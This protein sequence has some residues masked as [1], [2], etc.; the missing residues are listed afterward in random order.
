MPPSVVA[1]ISAV[2]RLKGT[3][4]GPQISSVLGEWLQGIYGVPLGPVDESGLSVE[5]RSTDADAFA[6]QLVVSALRDQARRTVTVV[7]GVD[8]FAIVEEAPFAAPPR[9]RSSV[10]LSQPTQ[11]LLHRLLPLARPVLSLSHNAVNNVQV[12]DP[13]ELLA[14]LG[15]DLSPG[16][17]IA[18]TKSAQDAPTRSQ[19]DLLR[20]LAGLAL[21]G[22][23]AAGAPLL[24]M[25]GLSSEPGAGSVVMV[26][27][28]A[29]GLNAQLI[30]S[31]S[32]LTK[33]DSARRLAVRR[34]LAAPVPFDLERRR[35]SAMKTLVA[36]G[37]EIDL[38]AA[39]QLLDE[40][41]RRAD[42]LGNRVRELETLLELAYDDQDQ[43]LGE[44][45]DAHSRVRYL[46]KA[47]RRLGAV[48]LVEAE[49]DDDWLPESSV[50]AI[51]AARETLPFLLIGATESDCELLDLHQKRSIW[52]KKI[53]N[54]L[55][56]LN[57]YCLSKTEGRFSGDIAMYRD[58]APDGAIP[59]LADYAA[60]ESRSTKDDATLVALRTFA[61]PTSVSPSGKAFMEQHV[62]I[63]RIGQG[64]PR[65]HL[66]DDSGG[67][68]Q[69]IFIGYV[70]P[71]L[72]TSSGF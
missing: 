62:K 45:D 35:S 33:P 5:W 53:W 20:G 15:E 7:G 21:A 54:S 61:V 50:D 40:E 56:A 32:L 44:L 16:L 14:A 13:D 26:A 66:L 64:A 24:S 9:S 11:G 46:Q 34:Q 29:E 37:S 70:G 8:A 41:A 31:T 23:A 42:E 59:L 69:R 55:R 67:V 25:V 28:T 68:T 2:I 6:C 39:L 71:H 48:P 43:A 47:I 27:R 72:P 10:Y 36:G 12:F 58:N 3:A 65:I 22:R 30:G 51:V 1:P 60:T 57:D 52:A 63:D 19:L 17:V 49:N 4:T 38:P 18:V